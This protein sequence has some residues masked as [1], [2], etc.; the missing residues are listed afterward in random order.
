[1][2]MV[3]DHDT[4]RGHYSLLGDVDGLAY[5]RHDLMIAI[6]NL[7]WLVL[8]MLVWVVVSAVVVYALFGLQ[9]ALVVA[10]VI[11]GLIVWARDLKN[12]TKVPPPNR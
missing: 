8:F 7:I 1:M 6:L 4:E 10:A 12:K 9:T 2:Y 11:I 3:F 5:A